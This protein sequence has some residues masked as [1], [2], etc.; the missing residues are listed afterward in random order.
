[1]DKEDVTLFL[2][3]N[4][5]MQ[6]TSTFDSLQ[7]KNIHL[8]HDLEL[9]GLMYSKYYCKSSDIVCIRQLKLQ[10]LN[11]IQGYMQTVTKYL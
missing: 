3:F 8:L 9:T 2:R 6:T 1:V 7:K 10:T 11:Y 5:Q 4:L